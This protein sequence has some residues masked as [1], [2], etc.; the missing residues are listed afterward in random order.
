MNRK[1]KGKQQQ[2]QSQMAFT[3]AAIVACLAVAVVEDIL[4]FATG[5]SFWSTGFHPVS[6]IAKAGRLTVN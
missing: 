2:D 3:I 4:Y 6:I 1:R 5:V